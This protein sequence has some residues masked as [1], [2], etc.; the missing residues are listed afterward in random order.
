MG[1]P[2]PAITGMFLVPLLL[3][4]PFPSPIFGVL[5]HR[6]DIGCAEAEADF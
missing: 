4:R 6:G 1:G 5:G 2:A 3:P